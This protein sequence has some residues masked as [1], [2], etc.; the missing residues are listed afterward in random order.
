[1]LALVCLLG[2]AAC[3]TSARQIGEASTEGAI[4]ALSEQKKETA[5]EGTSISRE[6]AGEVTKGFLDALSSPE[7]VMQLRQFVDA[8]VSQS[9]RSA[10]GGGVP[11]PAGD[12]AG[13]SGN[14]GGGGTGM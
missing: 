2:L 1:M 7:Q 14:M 10:A 4:N 8:L 3:A 13:S 5:S 11:G 12:G 9:L 6:A